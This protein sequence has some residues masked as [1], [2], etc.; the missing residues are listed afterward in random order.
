MIHYY[1][2][3]HKDTESAYG[4]SFPD[5]PGCFAAA[6]TLEDVVPAAAEALDLW[7]EDTET[8]TP[9]PLEQVV[10]RSAADLADGAFVISV[11]W[12]ELSGKPKRVN[13]SI[14]GN[15]LAAIDK[16]AKQRNVS[17]SAFLAASAQS[18][19]FRSP[20]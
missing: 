19:M 13:I 15:I 6:D 11:P 4:V 3:V 12:V 2:I 8:V 1:A 16:A 14:D 7:F 17:R 5:L 9:S 10:T 18:M 20:R